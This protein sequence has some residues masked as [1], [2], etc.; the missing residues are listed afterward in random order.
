MH[1]VTRPDPQSGRLWWFMLAGPV[2]YIVYFLV[3]YTLG[4]F[5][6]IAG[7]QRYTLFGISSIVIGVIASTVVAAPITLLVGMMSYRRWRRF[8]QAEDRVKGPE[9]GYPQFMSFVGLW[10]NGMFTVLILLTAVPMLL[11]SF[12][13]WL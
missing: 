7:I 8:A 6:C 10:L 2:V 12:C 4:E 9:E 11:G 3:V 1:T 5:G 13:E